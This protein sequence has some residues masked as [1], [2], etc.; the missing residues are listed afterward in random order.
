MREAT[1]YQKKQKIDKAMS[2]AAKQIIVTS[3]N[4]T[5]KDS[6]YSF[7]LSSNEFPKLPKKRLRQSVIAIPTIKNTNNLL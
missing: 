6:S 5:N 4:V 1:I 2:K 3:D 7:Q